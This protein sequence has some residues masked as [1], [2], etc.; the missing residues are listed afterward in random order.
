[1][2]STNLLVLLLVKLLAV[3]RVLSLSVPGTPSIT[4]FDSSG[5]A[6]TSQTLTCTSVGGDP[7][8]TLWWYQNSTQV[9][10]SFQVSSGTST[11][12]NTYT[13]VVQQ[14]HELDRIQFT[15]TARNTQASVSSSV[16][17]AIVYV[18][19]GNPTMTGPSTFNAGD[20][21]T[22]YCQ[23]VGGYP[24]PSIGWYLDGEVITGGASNISSA[25]N[26]YTV[27]S[28]YTRTALA[29]DHGKTLE[30]RIT[31]ASLNSPKTTTK[32]FTVYAPPTVSITPDVS[33]VLSG[34]DLTLTCSVSS[35][36]LSYTVSWY[37]DGSS[38][39]LTASS[40]YSLNG[41]TITILTVE[42]AD[43]GSYSCIASN[44]AGSSPYSNSVQVVLYTIPTSGTISP[45]NVTVELGESFTVTCSAVASP[46]TNTLSYSWQFGGNEIST[47]PVLTVTNVQKDDDGVYLC[48]A[49][50]SFGSTSATVTADVQYLPESAVTDPSLTAAVGASLSL[51]CDTDAN[52]GA[53]DY[54]WFKGS[55]IL[56][57][58][59]R[60]N[61]VQ[62]ESGTTTYT[63]RATNS[64]GTSSDITFTVTG[65]TSDSGSEPDTG[66]STGD[67]GTGLSVGVIVAIVLGILFLLF[68]II[69]IIVCCICS[70]SCKKKDKKKRRVVPT[71]VPDEKPREQPAYIE[72]YTT[73]RH[74]PRPYSGFEPS[75]ISRKHVDVDMDSDENRYGIVYGG[76]YPDT[77]RS[78]TSRFL[79]RA[80]P[81]AVESE[82]GTIISVYDDSNHVTS[83]RKRPVN[84]PT[85]HTYTELDSVR[86]EKRRRTKK[87][88]RHHHKRESGEG[89]ESPPRKERR[90]RDEYGHRDGSQRRKERREESNHRRSRRERREEEDL[91]EHG[92]IS[93][94]SPP[95][96]RNNLVVDE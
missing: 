78:T 24:A 76:N 6:G 95:N 53:T 21:N 80:P 8:P 51:S 29:S 75:I 61:S 84:L 31:H 42:Q 85:E 9:D 1:M 83:K 89:E 58:T 44:S 43:A 38:S 49:T 11:T 4:G 68:I 40:T 5:I 74:K 59:E 36:L 37:K 39:F 91:G 20:S 81:T 70:G 13:F 79:L 63:C 15:C 69:L 50:N 12:V 77:N 35:S 45:S 60:V 86:K 62:A 66:A 7:N 73:P 41:D 16:Q 18:S 65:T 26:T 3:S 28:S 55:A 52:P 54:I 2:E 17:F 19:P 46:V 32:T 92:Y 96:S 94:G 23:T 25:N 14:S 82:N 64:I 48:T 67:T 56:S 88:K 93:E 72:T 71:V 90:E 57:I 34:S 47:N 33:N 27:L 30:C 22:W 87:K 10:S